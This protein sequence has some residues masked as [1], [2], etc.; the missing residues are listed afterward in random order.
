MGK[1]KKSP[2]A[3]DLASGPQW[4][5]AFRA[6]PDDMVDPPE[7]EER[8]GKGR[9]GQVILD[10]V[11]LMASWS[12][13]QIVLTASGQ[14]VIRGVEEPEPAAVAAAQ[15][16]LTAMKEDSTAGGKQA[17]MAAIGE[18]M[19]RTLGRASQ[20]I[21]IKGELPAAVEIVTPLCAVVSRPALPALEGGTDGE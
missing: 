4:G 1:K 20:A 10:W 11:N 17:R 9:A 21:E 12:P 7:R 16:W 19:D 15:L 6:L 14:S 2:L 8:T 18:I 5:D 3:V 13:R